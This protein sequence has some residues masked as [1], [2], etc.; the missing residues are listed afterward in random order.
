MDGWMADAA[1]VPLHARRPERVG[2]RVRVDLIGAKP[3]IWR[4]LA[5]ASDLTLERV[6]TIIQNAMGWESE[7]PHGFSWWDPESHRFQPTS[8]VTRYEERD[9]GPGQ[10]GEWEVELCEVLRAPGDK[11]R[12]TY[13]FGDSW[14]HLPHLEEVTD[15]ETDPRLGSGESATRADLSC[16]VSAEAAL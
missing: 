16:H 8:F 12:Y 5:L 14:H 9:A 6:H 10:R 15:W 2:Y 3:P 13:D 4:R 7:H 11:F 1:V